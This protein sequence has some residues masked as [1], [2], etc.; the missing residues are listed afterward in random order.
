M[1]QSSVKGLKGYGVF[2]TRDLVKGEHIM[3]VPDGVSI[4]I[5]GYWQRGKGRLERAKDAW[6][7]VW[8]NYWWVS[9][10]LV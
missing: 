4:P 10:F 5:I 2:T 7:S 3:G 9:Q 6:M 1:A 8:D